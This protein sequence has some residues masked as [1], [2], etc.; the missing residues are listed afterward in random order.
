[1]LTRGGACGRLKGGPCVGP[2]GGGLSCEYYRCSHS[3]LLEGE[4][5]K[6]RFNHYPIHLMNTR[7]KGLGNTL[8]FLDLPLSYTYALLWC[9]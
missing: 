1:M 9:V 6:K 2:G 5:R 4:I 3:G 8:I 7:D